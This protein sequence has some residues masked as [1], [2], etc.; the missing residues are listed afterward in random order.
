MVELRIKM[1]TGENFSQ[2]IDGS[3]QDARQVIE[4][5]PFIELNYDNGFVVMNTSEVALVSC[6]E[7]S[8]DQPDNNVHTQTS[9]E[10]IASA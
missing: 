8:D 4:G 3:I 6:V 7:V 2:R 10:S 1:K 9:E 5:R